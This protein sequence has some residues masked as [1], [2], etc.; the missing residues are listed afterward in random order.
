[1]EEL[2]SGLGMI[3]LTLPAAFLIFYIRETAR[4]AFFRAQG[5][6]P[7]NPFYYIDAVAMGTLALFGVSWGG[8][9]HRE[10]NET[11]ISYLISQG[12]Y[13][14]ITAAIFFYFTLKGIKSDHFVYQL[15]QYS[16]KFSWSL[17]IFN[18]IP[19]PPF[20][21]SFALFQAL[22]KGGRGI[23]ILWGTRIVFIILALFFVQSI[24]SW[25]SGEFLIHLLK[26]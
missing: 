1:M 16:M 25:I 10:R 2:L 24:P 5:E 17:F 3:S 6:S 8:I 19:F 20:D 7:R 14:L 4:N 22:F 15:L 13:L 18:L 21:A 9:I 23:L 11:F 12:L 26:G